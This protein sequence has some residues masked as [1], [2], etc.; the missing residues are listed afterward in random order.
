[1]SRSYALLEGTN[2]TASTSTVA[3]D[4]LGRLTNYREVGVYNSKT[5]YENKTSP[6]ESPE[7]FIT[8]WSKLPKGTS[9]LPKGVDTPNDMARNAIYNLGERDIVMFLEETDSADA[10]YRRLYPIVFKGLFYIPDFNGV[11]ESIVKE[12]V[13]RWNSSC[14]NDEGQS[15]YLDIFTGSIKFNV[16]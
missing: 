7:T 11:S 4:K 12:I 10:S 1:M 13:S 14:Y 15:E 6:T 2:T 3:L 9:I 8:S 5:L 16:D